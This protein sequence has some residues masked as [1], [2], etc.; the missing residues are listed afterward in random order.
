MVPYAVLSALLLLGLP[1]AVILENSVTIEIDSVYTETTRLVIIPLTGRGVARFTTLT[2]PYREGWEEVELLEARTGLWRS[3][4][5]G[6]DAVVREQPHRALAGQAR[7]ESSMRELVLTMPGLETGDTVV[8]HTRRVIRSLPLADCYNYQYSPVSRD[9]LAAGTFTVINRRGARLFTEWSPAFDAPTTVGNE[10]RFRV[11]PA[12]PL[13]THPLSSSGS[14]CIAVSTHDPASVSRELFMA[15]DVFPAPDAALMAEVVERAGRTPDSLR[16]WVASNIEYTGADIGDWPGFTPKA[17]GETLSDGA[18]VCR[19]TAVLLLHLIRHTG[20]EAWLAMLDTTGSAPGLVG[21]RSFNHM[22]VV[23][24]SEGGFRVLDPSVMGVADGHSYGLRGTRFLP[25]TAAGSPLQTV[26]LEGW[27]DRLSLALTGRL[28]GGVI[29]GT[30]EVRA[31]GAPEELLRTIVE[32]VPEP[33]RNTL[34]AR[35]FQALS[36]SSV[37]GQGD[38]M[39]V[40]GEWS[41]PLEDGFLLLPGLRE[42]SLSGTRAAHLLV[43]RL[44]EGIRLDAPA[45]ESLIITLALGGAQAVLPEPVTGRG[46]SCSLRVHAD[47]LVMSERAGIL[48]LLP[49]PAIIRETLLLRSGSSQRT[50]VLR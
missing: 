10:L 43:P 21:S 3:G 49:D 25:L 29:R 26:P 34:I 19:D 18:G 47:T 16:N 44:P 4:R 11:G 32:R 1:D 15:L 12:G 2:V 8:V 39:L 14:P 6:S 27:D 23:T 24:P 17:P 20:G 40:E 50:V 33:H 22:V 9:S 42:L 38:S 31:S 30:L 13:D 28:D 46:Y 41:A 37:T 5:R 45:D 36:V 7:L 35:F 48:P